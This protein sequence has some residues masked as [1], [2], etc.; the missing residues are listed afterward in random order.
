MNIPRSSTTGRDVWL[1][2][3]IIVL[4]AVCVGIVMF[5]NVQSPIRPLL[6]FWFLLICPGM[7]MVRPLRVRELYVRLTLAVALS[8]AV[9][10]AGGLGSAATAAGGRK[11]ALPGFR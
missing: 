7:A 3:T 8:V 11:T 6:A 1:W 9:R 5:A 2:P 4:S 10:I